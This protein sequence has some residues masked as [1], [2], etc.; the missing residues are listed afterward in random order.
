MVKAAKGISCLDNGILLK[1]F[2]KFEADGFSNADLERIRAKA[3]T[4]FYG[5][6]SSVLNKASQLGV[7]NEFFGSPGKINDGLNNYL[8]IDKDDICGFRN[9]VSATCSDHYLPV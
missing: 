9:S 3:I 5:G 8:T 7:Y 2:A 4:R 1:A 6:L